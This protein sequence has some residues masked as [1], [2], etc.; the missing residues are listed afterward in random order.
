MSRRRVLR[1][2]SK[3]CTYDD[4]SAT[5]TPSSAFESAQAS[6]I[7]STF[8]VSM[9]LVKCPSLRSC[10]G[11]VR[12]LCL[13]GFADVAKALGCRRG[14][15]EGVRSCLATAD[16][17]I[18]TV[19]RCRVGMTVSWAVHRSGVASQLTRIA[20]TINEMP[21]H[22]GMQAPFKCNSFG[23]STPTTP[24]SASLTCHMCE[25]KVQS[26]H[27]N[28]C[29]KEHCICDRN[30]EHCSCYYMHE[31][32]PA[33]CCGPSLALAPVPESK[34]NEVICMHCHRHMAQR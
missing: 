2:E 15:S 11:R 7:R 1:V 17:N 10:S 5:S 30:L 13:S 14:G 22:C 33:S 4:K 31:L 25:S 26:M 16:S 6:R 18:T 34:A 12:L 27:H 20:A 8:I 3:S 9:Y 24:C 23:N 32:Q 28:R 19:D 29:T 21:W